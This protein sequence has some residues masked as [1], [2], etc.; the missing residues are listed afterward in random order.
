MT[1]RVPTAIL[2][3]FATLAPSAAF[4]QAVVFVHRA[5]GLDAAR[6]VVVKSA[7]SLRAE[8]SAKDGSSRLAALVE[9]GSDGRVV[10][11]EREL[12]G[13]GGAVVGRVSLSAIDEGA[14][15]R[16]TG[17][18]GSRVRTAVGGAFDV[19]IDAA[20]PEALAF[21]FADRDRTSFRALLV[22]E[23]EIRTVLVERR[24]DG[25]RYVEIPGGGVTVRFDARGVL[26]LALPGATPRELLREDAS[27]KDEGPPE[28]CV[29]R[30]IVVETTDGARLGGVACLPIGEGPPRA[31][32]VFVG[33]AGPLDRDGLGGGR[34]V[35]TLRMLAR[36]L[37]KRGVASV[38]ADKRGVAA[39][40]TV[41]GG[42]D[43]AAEDAA[44]LLEV[45]RKEAG[46]GP[47]RTIFVGH[48]EGAIVVVEAAASRPASVAGVVTLAGPG[49][50]LG[51]ALD[52]RLRARLAAAGETPE[53]IEEACDALKDEIE[54]LKE[55]PRESIAPGNLLLADLAKI[56]PAAR[57]SKLR[58]PSLIVH[59]AEDP[60]TPARHVALLRA[61]LAFSERRVRFQL[62]DRADHDLTMTAAGGGATRPP[63]ASADVARALHPSVVALILDFVA[64]IE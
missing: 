1:S 39:G 64:S 37:A 2:A 19:V 53:A 48:G 23:A 9:F 13:D 15:V 25:A 60:E 40:T 46:V 50:S 27:L 10:A 58:V 33:D 61:A 12:R 43:Q 44:K 29:E 6:T 8:G 55:A 51:E 62:V 49:R 42:L 3:L 41:S 63:P 4:A 56:D 5:Q 52:A 38:R 54:K 36:D 7:R 22:S 35:P 14:R 20:F 11:Y 28:G 18:F 30:P 24:G 16:E 47:E 59:G 17:P 34:H 21:A 57:I 32:A 31:L 45:G 26:S